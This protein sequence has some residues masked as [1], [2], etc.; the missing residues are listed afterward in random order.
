MGSISTT[1]PPLFMMR[2]NHIKIDE[3]PTFLSDTPSTN[4]QL[5][6]FSEHKIRLPL[7]LDGMISD[8]S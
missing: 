6:Y 2:L 3:C 8:L 1:L 7:K 4:N 5:I